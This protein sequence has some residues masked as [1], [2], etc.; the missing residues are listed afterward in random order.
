MIKR[1]KSKWR[2]KDFLITYNN[3]EDRASKVNNIINRTIN[4]SSK[5][6][7]E[8]NIYR[9]ETINPPYSKK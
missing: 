3:I 2:N 8:I 6:N 7:I 1:L 5:K 4:I 9:S